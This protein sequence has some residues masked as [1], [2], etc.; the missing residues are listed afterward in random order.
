MGN[1]GRAPREAAMTDL[2]ITM[3]GLPVAW[4]RAG[5][6]GGISFTPKKQRSAMADLKV[7]A[8]QAMGDQAP[9]A[10]ALAVSMRFQYPWPSSWSGKKRERNRWRASRPDA[11]NLVKLIGDSLNGIVWADDAL[12]ARIEVEK[13]YG[14]SAFTQITVRAA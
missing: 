8:A 9:F 6:K 11:D 3:P 5:R 4:A 7:I 2:V 10:G 14:A 12:I 13:L 1:L